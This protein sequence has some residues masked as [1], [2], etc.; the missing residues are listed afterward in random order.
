[1]AI[2]SNRSNQTQIVTNAAAVFTAVTIADTS[3]LKCDSVIKVG[4]AMIGTVPKILAVKVE[5]RMAA[6]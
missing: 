6:Q 2:K 3:S 5:F 1:M 4:S